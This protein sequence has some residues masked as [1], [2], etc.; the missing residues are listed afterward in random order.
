MLFT[1]LNYYVPDLAVFILPLYLIL[2]LWWGAGLSFSLSHTEGEHTSSRILTTLLLSIYLVV[3]VGRV[4]D[5]WPATADEQLTQWGAGV[6]S[7]PLAENAAIL[8]DGEKIAP[9][10]YWQQAEGVRPDLDIMVLPDEAAYRAELS[11][12][13]AAAQTVYLARFLPGLEGAYYL[14]SQ[15]PLTEVGVTPLITLPN[16]ALPTHLDFGAVQ[17]VGYEVEPIATVATEATAITLYWQ[18]KEAISE[19]QHVFVRWAGGE[20]VLQT[21]QH[22]V[23]NNYPTVAWKD[24]EIVVDY[25]LLPH[26]LAGEERQ[27]SLEVALAAPFTAP[28]G[29]QNVAEVIVP[30]QVKLVEERPLRVEVGNMLLTG[31]AFTEQIRPQM[32]TI[33]ALTGFGPL[34]QAKLALVADDSCCGGDFDVARWG[35]GFRSHATVVGKV[36][37][38]EVPLVADVPAGTYFLMVQDPIGQARCSWLAV[39]TEGCVLG[40]INVGGVP[41]PENAT[42][43]EDKIALTAIDIPQITLTSGGQL[44]VNLSW[45]SLAPMAEDYTVFVQVLD[46]TDQLVGQV[47]AWPLQGTYPTS[48]WEPGEQ[49]EDPYI[50]QLDPNLAPGEYRLQV[51]WYLL[52]TL[53]R[54]PV[55]DMTGVPVDDKVVMSGLVTSE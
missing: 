43:F 44:L 27:L 25:H 3:L 23:N 34:P 18:A 1:G 29:W 26:P 38:V 2:G 52:S 55:V 41:V 31:I 47:D 54:L 33:I 16:T 51:G 45:Q 49:I 14:R 30:P 13:L 21:G 53:R 19:V 20:P 36:N 32:E 39:P 9:L 40:Q 15:G 37:A 7:L 11:A 17:L 5:R 50:V 46:S 35:D 28:A 4:V 24:G 12:R 10:Y 22:P 8:A 42:N 48:Q 6:L